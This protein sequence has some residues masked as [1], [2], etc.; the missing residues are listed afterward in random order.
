MA[1]ADRG[2]SR[3]SGKSSKQID[4]STLMVGDQVH[5]AVQDG[6]G[7]G[8]A[9]HGSIVLFVDGSRALLASR[10]DVPNVK[11]IKVSSDLTGEQEVGISWV[12][13]AYLG[14]GHKRCVSTLMLN[15]DS[16]W[17]LRSKILL[18]SGEMSDMQVISGRQSAASSD[19]ATSERDSPYPST[20]GEH[21]D[22]GTRKDLHA[23][24]NDALKNGFTQDQFQQRLAQSAMSVASEAGDVPGMGP[25]HQTSMTDEKQLRRIIAECFQQAFHGEQ[26]HMDRFYT[27]LEQQMQKITGHLD[28]W[29]TRLES[30]IDRRLGVHSDSIKDH[31]VGLQAS[32]VAPSASMVVQTSQRAFSSDLAGGLQGA[33]DVVVQDKSQSG[34]ASASQA[35]GSLAPGVPHWKHSMSTLDTDTHHAMIEKLKKDHDRADAYRKIVETSCFCYHDN[36]IPPGYVACAHSPKFN[37]ICAFITLLFALMVGVEVDLEMRAALDNEEGPKWTGTVVNFFNMWFALEVLIRLTADGHLFFIGAEWKWNIFDL[38]LVFLS[39][40]DTIADTGAIGFM[41][42]VRAIKLVKALRVVRVLRLFQELRMMVAQMLSSMAALFWSMMFLFVITYLCAVAFV[43]AAIIYIKDISRLDKVARDIEVYYPDCPKAMY[44]LVASITGGVDWIE[45]A[46]AIWAFGWVYGLGFIVFVLVSTLGILN[47]VTSVFVDRAR[48]MKNIDRDY[49]I[50]EELQAMEKDVKETMELFRV[51][52]PEK[53]GS[54]SLDDLHMFLSEDRVIAH[55]ATIGVDVTDRQ[56]IEFLLEEKSEENCVQ[57]TGTVSINSFVIGCVNLRGGAKQ[58]D[59]L[60]IVLAVRRLESKL[61]SVKMDMDSKHIQIGRLVEAVLS[62]AQ[63]WPPDIGS[64]T[65]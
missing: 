34:I 30:E 24:V 22:N 26:R 19:V 1:T 46:D 5:F 36:C 16:V 50:S 53:K 29:G 38:S 7:G 33:V 62:K 57:G 42:V 8:P 39:I 54:I 13:V 2:D 55:F 45:V 31:C 59:T 17:S 37:Q 64:T 52:D 51:L 4:P 43:Q 23:M 9:R 35:T 6:S 28:S 20:P 41:R 40:L 12:K 65:C 14:R 60:S 44:T 21:S 10:P 49:A 63:S 58:S 27:T 48:N 15:L 56:K 11:P 18:Q 3:A 25:L 61:T 47:V 32:S